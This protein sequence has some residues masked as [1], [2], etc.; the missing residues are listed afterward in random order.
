LIH[1]P[2]PDGKQEVQLAGSLGS[3]FDSKKET[4]KVFNGGGEHE[5]K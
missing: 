2:K 4:K 5:P 1:L 3:N